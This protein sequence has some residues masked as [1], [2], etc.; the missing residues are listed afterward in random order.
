MPFDPL[1]VV[2]IVGTIAGITSF[3]VSTIENIN[4]RL[5]NYQECVNKLR[6]YNHMVETSFLELQEWSRLWSPQRAGRCTPYTD[7][8]YLLFWGQAGFAGILDR[9]ERICQEIKAIT[10]LLQCRG[11]RSIGI[12]RPS[13]SEVTRWVRVLS[14]PSERR[15]TFP[16]DEEYEIWTYKFLFAIY[17]DTKIKAKVDGLGTLISE[18]KKTS[19]LRFRELHE[20]RLKEPD[21]SRLQDLA[22]FQAERKLL[23]R[24]LDALYDDNRDSNIHWDL[25]LGNPLLSQALS[26]LRGASKT[27]LAFEFLEDVAGG[28]RSIK[29]VYPR[30]RNVQRNILL[31]QVQYQVHSVFHQHHPLQLQ[32]FTPLDLSELTA[33]TLAALSAVRSSIL[34]YNSRWIDGLC[35][36]G[37]NLYEASGSKKAAANFTNANC[38][39]IDCELRGQVFL[40]L[41]VLLAEL[42]MGAPIKAYAPNRFSTVAGPQFEVPGEFILPGF[43]NRM[44]WDTLS[45]LLSE[46]IYESP[47]QY[48]SFEYLEAMNYC[49]EISQTLAEREFCAD[50]LEICIKRIM[51]P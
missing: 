21:P 7:E 15:P 19:V 13:D 8:T 50:D 9:S 10:E 1:S 16:S 44:A 31:Q 22:N 23:L 38:V 29:V 36:C 39:H 6:D 48:I 47:E 43:Q 41:A 51:S 27:Q 40:L 4:I 20:A 11:I 45:D 25:V 24:F 2:G 3:L 12:S 33:Y 42:S 14:E 32:R 49:F 18:L 5:N 34:L 26:R 17:R 35:F 28:R 46:R 30:D 37:I